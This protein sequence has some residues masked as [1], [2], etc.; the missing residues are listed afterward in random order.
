MGA[1]S[2]SYRGISSIHQ[3][4]VLA[5]VS[6]VINRTSYAGTKLKREATEGSSARDKAGAKL[7]SKNLRKVHL[8]PKQ[9]SLMILLFPKS[10]YHCIWPEFWITPV[11]GGG[12][13][14]DLPSDLASNNKRQLSYLKGTGAV[15]FSL[16]FLKSSS[17]RNIVFS[18]INMCHFSKNSYYK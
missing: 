5:H 9:L 8:I 13:T 18:C 12:L 16:R 4:S 14:E 15:F 3:T 10:L 17:L 1:C 6:T 7:F 2:V 11:L